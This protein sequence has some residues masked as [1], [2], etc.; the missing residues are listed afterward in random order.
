M[1]TDGG[2]AM[3]ESNRPIST[4]VPKQLLARIDQ[5]VQTG[6][7]ASRSEYLRVALLELLLDSNLE[8]F[9]EDLLPEIK[10]LIQSQDSD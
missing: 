7:F 3:K 2:M 4:K 8:Q 10:E 6:Q 5:L 9:W 1:G